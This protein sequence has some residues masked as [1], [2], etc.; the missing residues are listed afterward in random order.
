MVNDNQVKRLFKLMSTE[1]TVKMAA[2][3]TGMDEKTARKY[4]RCGKLPSE[5]ETKHDWITRKN[6]FDLI[7]PDV[8][9]KLNLNPG[10]DAKFLF[11]HY[12]R[13][14]PGRY[15]DGQ[16]RTFQR[17]IKQWRALEGPPKEVYFPQKHHPGELSQSDFTDMSS[18]GVT[19]QKK[20]FSHLAYHFVLTFSNW[21][22]ATVCFSESF[23]SLSEGLQHALWKLGG[24]TQ[25]H[26]TD[27]LSAAVYNDLNSGEFTKRYE[28]LLRH[29]GLKGQRTNAASPHE[30]GDIEQRHYRFKRVVEQSLM[31]RGSRD[32]NN[33]KEYEYFLEKILDQLN[34]GRRMALK[35]EMKHLRPLPSQRI[36]SF[37]R[38]RLRVG[39][40][41]T[42]RVAHNTYSVDSRLIGENIDVR[43]YGEY[44]E[45]WYGQKKIDCLPRLRG[46][47]GHHIEYRHIIDSL[48]RKPGAFANYRYRQDMFPTHRFRM[49]YDHLKQRLNG[50]GDK[51]YLALLHL[52]ARQNES[53]VDQALNH[54]LD[55]E[56][57]IELIAVKKLVDN[58]MAIDCPKDVRIDQVELSS[59]DRLLNHAE[60]DG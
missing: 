58:Q 49:A 6:P 7:W 1:N 19:I 10:M 23:E 21:E 13:T 15:Q 34:A 52:A 32:F 53:A 43:L 39:P 36:D 5:I 24:V 27:R 28:A 44:L 9:G 55:R 38:L 29:Y 26:R 18:L 50:R 31:L 51:A 12:Q 8:K 22:T 2:L 42:I 45:V 37:K 40:W 3:K 46:E 41:S 54:L 17:K 48:V 20:S 33:K 47:D 35:E 4:L 14:Y 11:E 57:P 56:Q 60:V 59:Y 25:S 30:N 16:L